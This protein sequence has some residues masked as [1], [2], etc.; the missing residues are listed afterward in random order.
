[1]IGLP[2]M[3]LLTGGRRSGFELLGIGIQTR[4]V[5]RF[6]PQSIVIN[7]VKD[8]KRELFEVTQQLLIQ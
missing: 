5:E 1:M 8:L 2:R 7:D 4:S 3:T 6:F